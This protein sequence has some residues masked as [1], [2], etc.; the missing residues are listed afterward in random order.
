MGGVRYL[1]FSVSQAVLVYA[2]EQNA[3]MSSEQTY[4]S[5]LNSY[6]FYLVN[7]HI[8]S[9]KKKNQQQKVQSVRETHGGN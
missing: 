6:K 8:K 9:R 7:T 2:Q 3:V 4:L 1:K 5:T